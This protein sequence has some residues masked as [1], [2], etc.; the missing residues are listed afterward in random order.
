M[1]YG[2][3]VNLVN[4]KMPKPKIISNDGNTPVL[5]VRMHWCVMCVAISCYDYAI[6]WCKN[7]KCFKKRTE[8]DGEC[9]FQM[10]NLIW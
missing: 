9:N 1:Q 7:S 2:H 10:K 6:T 3:I 5:S 8:N 4:N